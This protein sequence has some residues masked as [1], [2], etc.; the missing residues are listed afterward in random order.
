MMHQALP[1]K[2]I[3]ILQQTHLGIAVGMS[4]VWTKEAE[5][6]MRSRRY[7]ALEERQE[8]LKFGTGPQFPGFCKGFRGWSLIRWESGGLSATFNPGL[9][10]TVG[11]MTSFGPTLSVSVAFV[12]EDDL[13]DSLDTAGRPRLIGAIASRTLSRA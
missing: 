3:Y 7:L 13:D 5:S 10:E 1:T 8:Y 11:F 2:E 4:Q 12:G 6:S 9:G